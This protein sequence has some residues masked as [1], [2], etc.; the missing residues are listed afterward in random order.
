MNCQQKVWQCKFLAACSC[1]TGSYR[2]KQVELFSQQH[3]W[4]YWDKNI[5]TQ[6]F[7]PRIQ[8]AHSL[9]MA[10]IHMSSPADSQESPQGGLD[11]TALPGIGVRG[12]KG[13]TQSPH[14]SPPVLK[15]PLCS[16]LLH[17]AE[18]CMWNMMLY[19]QFCCWDGRTNPLW[20]VGVVLLNAILEDAYLHTLRMQ[21]QEEWTCTEQE[22]HSA[23]SLKH[24]LWNSLVLPETF[25]KG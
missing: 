12:A 19:M 6:G 23:Q 10:A 7:R 4:N 8:T 20:Q 17:L 21:W 2:N 15:T 18:L 16:C 14:H 13:T 9:M 5:A 1:T 11:L 25:I 22:R 24:F 3:F